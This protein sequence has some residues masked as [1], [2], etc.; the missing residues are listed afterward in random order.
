MS[1][2]KKVKIARW[3][4]KPKSLPLSLVSNYVVLV[5][6]TQHGNYVEVASLTDPSQTRT[7]HIDNLIP[8]L[9]VPESATNPL[10]SGVF[11]GYQE[12]VIVW[13]SHFI[14]REN[15]AQ[16]VWRLA[17]FRNGLRNAGRDV[18]FSAVRTEAGIFSEAR[19]LVRSTYSPRTQYVMIRYGLPPDERLVSTRGTPDIEA[20]ER[21]SKSFE[22][23]V[24]EELTSPAPKDGPPVRK[25]RS[26]KRNTEQQELKLTADDS[27]ET[28]VSILRKRIRV[29]EDIQR[30]RNI[31]NNISKFSTL[32][33]SEGLISDNDAKSNEIFCADVTEEDCRKIIDFL[34]S[35]REATREQQG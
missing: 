31:K 28:E 29:L 8:V 22:H 27:I 4:Q 24:Q 6:G 14:L 11:W 1:S 10:S 33:L 20:F 21:L 5:S 15:L 3:I 26:S 9:H 19:N 18:P 32:Y 25:V 12:T 17:R 30:L 35:T 7:A 2:S 34:I 23:S 13:Y 16:I